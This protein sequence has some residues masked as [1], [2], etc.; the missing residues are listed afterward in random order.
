MKMLK[1]LFVMFSILGCFSWP[2]MQSDLETYIVQVESPKSQISVQSSRTELESWYSYFLP[3]A[4]ATTGSDEK[5]RLIYSYHNVMKGFAARLSAEEVKE[6]EKKK[7]F[8]SA[9]P[10]T[11]LPLH[12]THTPNFLGLQ[13]NMGL[14]RDSSYGKGVIIGVLDTGISPDH[15]SFS[16]K[17]MPPPPAKWKDDNGHGTHTASTAAGGFVKGANVFGNANGTAVGIAP[18]A[19]LAIYKV[20]DSSGCSN[21]DILAVMDTAI[22]DGVDILSLSL[23]GRSKPFIMM[24]LHSVR[25]L[26]HEEVQ[27][28]LTGNSRQLLSSEPQTDLDSRYCG[29]GTL[30]DPDIEGRLV[31]CMDGGGY[32]RIGKGQAVKDAGGVGMIIYNGPN[33]GFTKLADDNVL[34]ALFFT[35]QDGMNILTYM[36]STSEPIA[37]ISFHGTIIGDKDA[38]VVASFSSRGPNSGTS[39]SCPHLSG[40]AALLKSTH[41]TWSPA[42]INSAIMTTTNTVNL[43][44]NPILDERLLPANIFAIGAGHVNPSRA[45]DP[46]LVYDTPFNDY[47]PYLCGLNYTNGQIT[48]LL[49]HRVDCQTVRS[50]SEAQLRVCLV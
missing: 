40:V 33:G 15:P 2:S 30:N 41:P 43:A 31:L 32:S 20:C 28:L 39:M 35:Y 36:N 9:R 26:Q 1:I 18:L 48:D 45:N 17:G 25:L 23:G 4:I 42:A 47:L 44:N 34:P 38:P 7:G 8:I 46:G 27:A 50:I 19:H 22:D 21:S 24:L 10:Q 16:D 37:R 49:Q 14:W 11:I 29:T 3:K 6:M 5:P 13:Q 12:T